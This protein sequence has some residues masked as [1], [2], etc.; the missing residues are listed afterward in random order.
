MLK[1]QGF[2]NALDVSL[3]WL[4]S[5]I[6]GLLPQT[7]V[8]TEPWWHVRNSNEL[9]L[10]LCTGMSLNLLNAASVLQSQGGHQKKATV[11]I[12]SGSFKRWENEISGIF[13]PALLNRSCNMWDGP[14]FLEIP[15]LL[16]VY[17]LLMDF[18]HGWIS[19]PLTCTTCCVPCL[20]KLLAVQEWVIWKIRMECTL[21]WGAGNGGLDRRENSFTFLIILC[22]FNYPQVCFSF[23]CPLW[24]CEAGLLGALGSMKGEFLR[25]L[26]DFRV[27]HTHF[28][29]QLLS[30]L[31]FVC[32]SSSSLAFLWP[33]F[34]SSPP[35]LLSHLL[36]QLSVGPSC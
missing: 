31:L 4:E 2:W 36:T 15:Y 7:Q 33:V 10:T 23:P 24:E 12:F 20:G 14:A 26:P 6:A 30:L 35:P 22:L 5:Q 11:S 8:C 18:L 16:G 9:G 29:S 13:C 25:N 27:E 19:V 34:P 32:F 17:H 1:S 28:R 21:S 3:L